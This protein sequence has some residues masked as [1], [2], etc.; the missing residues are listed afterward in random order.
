MFNRRKEMVFNK[1]EKAFNRNCSN[2]LGKYCENQY[3][4]WLFIKAFF[5]GI[6]REISLQYYKAGCPCLP[7]ISALRDTGHLMHFLY[8]GVNPYAAGG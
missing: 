7:H 8:S 6:G 2:C 4:S 3:I 1:R 5:S